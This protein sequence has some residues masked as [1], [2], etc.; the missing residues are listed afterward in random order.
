[1]SLIV[2]IGQVDV[3]PDDASAAADLMRVMMEATIHEN[4]CWHYTYA[5]DLSVQNRFQLSEL[6]ESDRALAGHFETDHMASYR[7]GIA[8]LRVQ[9]RSVTR[10]EVTNA[11]DL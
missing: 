8:K 10:Y 7:A 5:R 1:M 2:I 4:G 6:W 9:K 11:V 3:H